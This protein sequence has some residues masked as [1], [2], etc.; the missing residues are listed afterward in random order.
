MNE[1]ITNVFTGIGIIVCYIFIGW[2]TL[3][4]FEHLDQENVD[5]ASIMIICLWFIAAPILLFYT[6]FFSPGDKE[7]KIRK[8]DDRVEELEYKVKTR[9]KRK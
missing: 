4:W 1:L 9:R 7:K 6:L 8:L 3:R 2:L 5:E